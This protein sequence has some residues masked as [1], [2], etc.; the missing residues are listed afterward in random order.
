MFTPRLHFY[1]LYIAFYVWSQNCIIFPIIS[2]MYYPLLVRKKLWRR[3]FDVLIF[4]QCLE[5][6]HW[7][8]AIFKKLRKI[9]PSTGRSFALKQNAHLHN[10]MLD[11]W[12]QSFYLFW[13][14][15]DQPIKWNHRITVICKKCTPGWGYDKVF[16]EYSILHFYDKLKNTKTK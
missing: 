12:D 4:T 11:K 3:V 5:S 9:G 15:S 7:F 10:F 2:C 16:R 14:W 6:M 13:G 1:C 8:L